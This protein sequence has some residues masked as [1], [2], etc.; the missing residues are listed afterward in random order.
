M[1]GS[2]DEVRP[3]NSLREQSLELQSALLGLSLAHHRKHLR[4]FSNTQPP[5]RGNKLRQRIINSIEIW[6]RLL[7]H[8]RQPT[9]N[10]K[11]R[12]MP[13]ALI[14]ID[15]RASHRRINPGTDAEL[16]LRQRS[17]QPRLFEPLA[18]RV[19]GGVT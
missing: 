6:R 8:L 5:V 12:L 2:R 7:Q 15:P 13:F 1:Y 11:R 10:L 16:R 19:P 18:D 4:S 9:D 3:A 14:L 17:L